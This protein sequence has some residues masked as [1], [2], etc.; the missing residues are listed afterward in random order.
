MGPSL[1]LGH[2]SCGQCV[3]SQCS[4]SVLHNALCENC[5]W[6]FQRAEDTRRQHQVAARSLGLVGARGS[7][8]LETAAGAVGAASAAAGQYFVGG[9]MAG[10]RS[11][12]AGA[13]LQQPVRLAVEVPRPASVPAPLP[14]DPPASAAP[15][16]SEGAGAGARESEAHRR[17][18]EL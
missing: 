6:Q 15:S 11:A 8:I 12:W 10:A 14:V 17:H 1:M 5:F 3:H 4:A 9:V 2:R 13:R 16:A 18:G 7:E